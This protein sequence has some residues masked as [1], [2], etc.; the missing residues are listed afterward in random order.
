MSLPAG[1]VAVAA[2]A[3]VSLSSAPGCVSIGEGTGDVVS[4]HLVAFECWDDAYDLQPDFFAADPFRNQMQIRLQRGDDL[5]EVSDGVSLLINDVELVQKSLG[6]PVAVSL[7]PG[8]APPGVAVGTVCGEAGCDAP[9][10]LALSL[11]E[12]CHSQNIV[13]YATS[14]TIT[15]DKLFSGDPDEPDADRRLTVARFDVVVADPRGWDPATGLFSDESRLTGEFRFI[16][17]RG[18]PAQP[19]P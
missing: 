12:S 16:F 7:P 15:F 10:H 6:A 2:W 11:L 1:R 4:D 19:F 9:V 13:L 8:V 18:Q 17:Q 5:V 14:G 3:A